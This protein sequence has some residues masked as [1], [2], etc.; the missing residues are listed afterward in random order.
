MNKK[1]VLSLFFSFLYA[2]ITLIAVL[3]HEIWADEAQV[4]QLCK[5]LSVPELFNHLH[6]EGHP[7]FFYLLTMLFAKL[8][9]NI[10]YM[11]LICWLFM[12]ASVFLLLYKSSF[13][14]IL[15]AAII[16]SAGFIYYFPVIARDYS[17][18]PFFVFMAAILYSKRKE[19][20]ILY[21]L[22]LFLLVNTHAIMLGFVGILFLLF[23]IETVKIRENL[24]SNIIALFLMLSGIVLLLLQLHDTTN[25]S[26]YITFKPNEILIN[27][28]KVPLFFFINTYN[29]MITYKEALISPAFDIFFILLIFICFLTINI[30]LFKNDK[31]LFTINFF[32]ICYQFIIYIFIYSQ[33]QYVNRIFCTYI[34]MIF[35][36]WILYEQNNFKTKKTIITSILSIFF[37]LTTFNGIQSYIAEIKSE[38]SGA[39]ETS[40]F[41]KNNIDKNSILM[42]T[43]EPWNLANMYYLDGEYKLYSMMAEKYINYM[44]WTKKLYPSHNYMKSFCEQMNNA[45][46]KDIYL[47]L[48]TVDYNKKHGMYKKLPDEEFSESFE[49]IFS[50]KQPLKKDEGFMIYK[51]KTD[52]NI[53]L[54]K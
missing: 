35:C 24:K 10:L 20:P 31:K 41:I 32:G 13:P 18:I 22:N 44:T 3:H 46:N 53:L 45:T 37:F 43:N 28:I 54:R 40:E 1:L 14:N 36:F 38:Y 30:Y 21:A 42:I 17:L 12:C 6:N 27:C 8:S 26:A 7:S 9:N 16:F 39:K 52:N 19:H 5:H 50:S 2:I 29:E 51:F 48:S 23:L 47:I 33:Y 4:W 15:K 49:H 25:S 34:I 11:Q